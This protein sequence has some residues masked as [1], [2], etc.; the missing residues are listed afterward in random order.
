[1]P[2][3]PYLP[4]AFCEL[5]DA[6][7]AY[8]RA[9]A[10]Y[11]GKVEEIY[12]SAK[13]TRLLM[14]FG[15]NNFDNFN[16]AHIPVDAIANKLSII[17]VS[18]DDET[19]ESEADTTLEDLW[20]Y[21]ELAEESRIAHRKAG[22]YGD[23]YMMVWPVIGDEDDY[24]QKKT[25]KE[26]A[27]MLGEYGD[28]T[29]NQP[30]P[31]EVT[32]KTIVA[33]DMTFHDPLTTRVFYS[34][35]NP[36]KKAFAIRS[37]TE[38]EK[39]KTLTRANLYY[40][41]RIE[42]YVYEGKPPRNR[43]AQTKWKPF[44]QDGEPEVLNNPFG[45]IPFFHFRND[46]PYGKP[47]HIN[48]YGPQLAINKLVTSHMATVDFQSFPQR[49]GLMDPTADQAGSQGADFNPFAPEDEDDPEFDDN[50]SQ[51]SADPSAFWDLKGYKAVG[52][53]APAS[54]DAYLKPF[55]RYVK[56][57]SQVTDTPMHFF[58][59]DST[60]RPP[61]GEML[62]VANEPID[63]KAEE[64]QETYGSTWRKALTFALEMMGIPTERINISWRP[65]ETV[66]DKTGWETVNL[67]QQAGVPRDV[68]LV[69]AGNPP[70]QVATWMEEEAARKAEETE[71]SMANMERQ[72]QIHAKYNADKQVV[73]NPNAP[74]N[75]SEGKS[76]AASGTE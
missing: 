30:E 26:L 74:T 70:E 46:R 38:G 49:Y 42:R 3:N 75:N 43:Y 32:S 35:E 1:M 14:K 76:P 31:E 41:D 73:K 18:A 12:S 7:P 4:Y 52:Q 10:F 50:E 54:P 63:A 8:E 69:W 40:P 21:N 2:I 66:T 57:M 16:F 27:D 34:N 33:V 72:A 28:L 20:D 19:D 47:D 58:A 64:R 17:A 45:E 71:E 48:A 53:F 39:D 29:V 22:V 23:Y 60:D 15:L 9:A 24:V 37:W 44:T 25:P 56:A 13:I 55:D 11:E 65:V 51:L 6:R 59:K 62:R 61:S 5:R 68:T 36:L 67:Q